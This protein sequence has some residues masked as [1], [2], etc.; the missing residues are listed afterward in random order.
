M[1]FSASASFT[2]AAGLVLA[3]FASFKKVQN[4]RQIMFAAI[5]ILFA[6]QQFSEGLVWL[7]ASGVLDAS[8]QPLVA[9]IFLIF[10]FVVWPTWIPS[11]LYLI[12]PQVKSKNILRFLMFCGFIMSG[13]LMWL[14]EQ[15]NV[16]AQIAASNVCYSITSF[17]LFNSQLFSL[18]LYL[19]PVVFPFFISTHKYMWLFGSAGLLSC[20]LT[21]VYKSECFV[22]VWCFFAAM[23]SFMLIALFPKK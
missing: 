6:L 7:I 12:E 20:F 23:L 5:P 15:G 10:A 16:T 21:L 13:V 17:E 18:L 2:A 4:R 1:C 3:S 19:F 8:L 11:S 22:S 14:F 9:R